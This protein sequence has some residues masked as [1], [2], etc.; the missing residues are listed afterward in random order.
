MARK[1]RERSKKRKIISIVKK[2]NFE[3]LIT[4]LIFLGSF[5]LLED[6][7][8][9]KF[10]KNFSIQIYESINYII[11]LFLSSIFEYII[12]IESSDIIG[13]ILIFSAIILMFLRWRNNLIYQYSSSEFCFNCKGKLQR[14]KRKI[15]TKIFSFLIRLKIKKYQ[16][17]D[18]KLKS[19]K[20]TSK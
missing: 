5:L 14:V 9:K 17:I 10:I 6:F 3:F 8:L 15:K 4:L 13:L 11:F 7:E 16:C 19:Y 18:C 12:K 20:I 1:K 2:Y